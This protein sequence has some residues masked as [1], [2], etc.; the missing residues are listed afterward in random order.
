MT[1]T[2]REGSRRGSGVLQDDA[3]DHVRDVFTL[4]DSGFN[5]FKNL[6][7]LDDLDGVFFLFE[8]LRDEG[9][10]DAV[11]FIFE[12]IDF[13]DVFERLVGGFHGMNG[14]GKFDGGRGE[15]FGEVDG[16]GADAVD[17]IEDEAAGGGVDQVDDVVHGAAE[18]VHVF[19]VERGDEGLVELGEDLVGDFVALMLDGLHALNLFGDAGVVFQHAGERVGA[20]DDVFGLFAE[21]DEE[22]PIARMKRCKNPGMCALPPEE[23]CVE[24]R[25]V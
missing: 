3:L 16:A 8:E 23:L 25:R 15:D 7:P 21:E 10:A 12:A 22:I 20:A 1:R 17:A 5:H 11:A 13:D 14:A 18:F 6:F 24:A 9:A 2:S 4:V 19:A